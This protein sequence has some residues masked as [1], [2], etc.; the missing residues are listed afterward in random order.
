MAPEFGFLVFQQ[1]TCRL[2]LIRKLSDHCK[3]VVVIVY[4]IPYRRAR[5]WPSCCARAKVFCIQCK[6]LYVSFT[7]QNYWMNKFHVINNTFCPFKAVIR[8]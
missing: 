6:Y 1:N 2:A 7:S 5:A 8:Q 3:Y 4:K